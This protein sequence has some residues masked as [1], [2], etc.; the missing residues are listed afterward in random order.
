VCQAFF[1][2][3]E[4]VQQKGSTI[5]QHQSLKIPHKDKVIPDI[6]SDHKL[7]PADNL[8]MPSFIK[9]RLAKFNEQFSILPMGFSNN[10][11]GLVHPLV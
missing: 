8:K 11:I 9:R 4:I 1:R 6:A 5:I 10:R 3:C 7:L 2:P